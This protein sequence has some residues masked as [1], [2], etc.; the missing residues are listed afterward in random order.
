M[1]RGEER[2]QR[3]ETSQYLQE[4]KENST[5]LVAASEREPA[6]TGFM[7][8]CKRFELGVT[9]GVRPSCRPAGELQKLC[10]AKSYW[11]VEP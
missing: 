8:A 7:E 9:G 10:L 4:R 3:T 11:K 1:H 2:T 5:S 6:Q